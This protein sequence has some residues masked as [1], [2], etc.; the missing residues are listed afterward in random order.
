MAYNNVGTPVFYVDQYLYLKT[1]GAHLQEH[2]GF[3]LH[4]GSYD[5]IRPSDKPELFT[6]NPSTPKYVPLAFPKQQL[7]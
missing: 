5:T 6:L 1:I 4:G 3:E 2:K 7:V